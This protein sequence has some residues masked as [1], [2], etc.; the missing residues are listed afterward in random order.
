[1]DWLKARL[2]EPSTHAGIASVAGAL[3]M[4]LPP[5]SPWQYAALAVTAAMGGSAA[6]KAD[7]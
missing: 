2:A 3:A 6:R 5:G 1:M 4:M 7:R